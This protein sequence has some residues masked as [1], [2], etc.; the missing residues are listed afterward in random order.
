[1]DFFLLF[2]LIPGSAIILL[3]LKDELTWRKIVFNALLMLNTIFFLSPMLAAFL[4]RLQEKAC[5]TG[6]PIYG[7]T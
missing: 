6:E 2:L 1:M 5:G 7:F 3:F 4:V